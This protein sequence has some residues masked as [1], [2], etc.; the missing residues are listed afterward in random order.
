MSSNP[1]Q[2]LLPECDL[3]QILA[4]KAAQRNDIKFDFIGK[5]NDFRDRVSAEVRQINLLFP[6]YTPHD[7]EYHLSRLFHVASLVLG[8]DRLEGMNSAELFILAISLYGH[9]WGMAVGESEKE[10]ILGDKKQT[11]DDGFWILRDEK[12]RFLRFLKKQG[13]ISNGNDKQNVPFETWRE[14]VRQTHA[15]R[16]G[17]RVRKY[18]ENIDGG[19]ADAAARV[20]IGHWLDFED[21]EDY[22]L[23]PQDFSVLRESV[24]LRALSVYLRLIDLLDLSE[25]RTPYVIWKFVAPR[26][27][28]ST[29][30][31]AKHRALHPITCPP[32]QQGRIIQVDGSTDD[33]EVYAALEDLRVWCEEQLRG[34]NDILA[35]MND[36]RHRLDIYHID[37]RVAARGFKPVL[38][39][40]EFNRERMFE[41]LGDDIYQSDPYVFLRELLQNSIDAIRVRRE[42]L[43]RKGIDPRDVGVIRV[44]V[45]H[46]ENCDA[47]VSWIDDGI[48]MDEFILRNYFAVAGKSYY[49]SAD[50]E[51]EGLNIDPISRFGIGFLSCFMVSNR[52]EIETYRDPYLPPPGEPLRVIIPTVKQQFRIEVISRESAEVGT[53]IRVYIEGN[54]LPKNDTTKLPKPLDITTY[55][56]DIAGFVEFPIVINEA[57][58]RT[59]ILHPNYDSRSVIERFGKEF[60]IHKI[61]FEYPWEDAFLP[62]DMG[63]AKENLEENSIDLS[64]DLGLKN[65]EGKFIYV[66]P[67]K[68]LNLYKK[69]NNG[70]DHIDIAGKTIRWESGWAYRG[71]FGISNRPDASRSAY[72]SKLCAVYRDGILVSGAEIPRYRVD[73]YELALPAPKIVVNL[74]KKSQ[75]QVNLARTE[76]LD[77][78]EWYEPILGAHL[79]LMIK[80][81]LEKSKSKKDPERSYDLGYLTVFGN[82][83]PQFLWREFPHQH[84]PILLLRKGGEIGTINWDRISKKSIFSLVEQPRYLSNEVIALLNSITVNKGKYDGILKN[85]IGDPSTFDLGE[86]KFLV[87]EAI[88]RI[89]KYAINQSHR[90]ESVRFLQSASDRFPPIKQGVFIPL[91]IP[92]EIL[93]IDIVKLRYKVQRDISS[94][95]PH[96]L[97]LLVLIFDKASKDPSKLNL[98]EMDLIKVLKEGTIA[99][100][101]ANFESPYDKFFGFGVSTINLKNPIGKTIFQLVGWITLARLQKQVSLDKIGNLQDKIHQ[102]FREQ[103]IDGLID[104]K[105]YK[106]FCKNLENLWSTVRELKLTSINLD[107]LI[108]DTVPLPEDFIPN[109]LIQPE[110]FPWYAFTGRR[111]L[112]L[113]KPFGDVLRRVK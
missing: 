93:D 59:I 112:K 92:K 26:D 22:H 51:R 89:C 71:S 28:K 56:S 44:N 106:S 78:E 75:S 47:I 111:R 45:N 29:M 105:M 20:C 60:Q 94:L 13:V 82:N 48:G 19:I 65:Y 81:I 84:I 36:T 83:G 37:W 76:L 95:S 101:F 109:T 58:R 54:K 46:K 85:W 9:D 34:C 7:E 5:L 30:E 23:Y 1:I 35:R 39:Q 49:R 87:T 53:T 107:A 52:V 96:E 64:D 17:E 73:D 74:P 69:D 113:V 43:K 99:C 14:Y 27:P 67:A 91:Q 55:L 97:G 31:W 79:N 102:L 10:F 63:L 88:S 86:C 68:K 62:Q 50:F 61:G 21:L 66:V 100:D 110:K 15:D 98:I 3:I 2:N 103:Y 104:I 57:D 38:M 6:E 108:R 4:D 25:D 41:I 40:F 33:H 11:S 70:A 12:Q 77:Q 18:F 24:N 32:Y 90:Q 42:V 72:H 16:S 8:R 80:E